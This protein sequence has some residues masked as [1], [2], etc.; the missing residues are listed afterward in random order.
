MPSTASWP[1]ERTL[2]SPAKE[3]MTAG[4]PTL[5][6]KSESR[7][8]GAIVAAGF[9]VAV[10]D[11]ST[12]AGP[13]NL[14]VYA[15]R[16]PVAHDSGRRVGNLRWPARCH[17]TLR[18]MYGA[19]GSA[20]GSSPSNKTDRYP[21]ILEPAG[22]RA[23]ITWPGRPFVGHSVSQ[24]SRAGTDGHRLLVRWRY[25]GR[26]FWACGSPFCLVRS[27]GASRCDRFVW[28]LYNDQHLGMAAQG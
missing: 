12:F 13:D 6:D 19:P 17:R 9:I 28:D 16:A 10:G 2:P 25:A 22:P 5:F 7:W 11:L 21:N 24:G 26:I 27:A 20:A 4:T 3:G 23:R 18:Y 15:G 1:A 8:F 14:A